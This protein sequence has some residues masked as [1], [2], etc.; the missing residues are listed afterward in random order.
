MLKDYWIF[1]FGGNYNVE[2]RLNIDIYN[3]VVYK[4]YLILL[5]IIKILNFIILCKIVVKMNKLN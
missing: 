3:N 5:L 4:K 1:V 2:I